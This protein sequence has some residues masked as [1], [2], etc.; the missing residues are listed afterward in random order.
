METRNLSSG[1]EI[2][3]YV[4]DLF[5]RMLPY[6]NRFIFASSCNTAID[7][8]WETIMTFRDAWLKFREMV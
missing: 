3:D 8:P 5:R 6:K 2:Y 1:K 4:E 7:T